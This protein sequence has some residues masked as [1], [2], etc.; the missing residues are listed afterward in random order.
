MADEGYYTQLG[1]EHQS[2]AAGD[3]DVV[4]FLEAVRD[5]GGAVLGTIKN[6]TAVNA[7]VSGGSINELP[8]SGLSETSYRSLLGYI[9]NI[10]GG[11]DSQ[12]FFRN[13][14]SSLVEPG[15]IAAL[16]SEPDGFLAQILFEIYRYNIDNAGS[17]D[18]SSRSVWAWQG[19]AGS[20]IL[21]NSLNAL[22]ALAE[23]TGVDHSRAEEP[24]NAED[25]EDAEELTG[26]AA[27]SF[28]LNRQQGVLATLNER[29]IQEKFGVQEICQKHI[30]P[31]NFKEEPYLINL[32]LKRPKLL[33]F[34]RIRTP[35]LSLLVPKIR[36]FKKV[37]IRQEDGTFEL[38]EQD[39]N[40]EFKFKSFTGNAEIQN[41]TD[42]NF[43]RA[44]GVGIKSANWSYEG[45]N[46][47][48][49]RSLLNFDLS[50]YFQSLS[51]LIGPDAGDAD[52]AL[53][54]T[55]NTDLINLIGAGVG[56]ADDFSGISRFK[57]E[58][59]AQLGWEID[60]SISHNLAAG[61]TIEEVQD[62]IKETNM[63]MRLALKEHNINFNE[64]GSLT[65]D[66]SYV[67]AID[68]VLASESL[69]IL[70]IGLPES[71]AIESILEAP[72]GNSSQG[73]SDE[74]PNL[75]LDPC[76]VS[77]AVTT[78]NQASNS[79]DENQ[80][81]S[82]R[83]LAVYEALTSSNED[84]IIQNYNSIFSRILEN[85]KIYRATVNV[86][87]AI[88]A[89]I[90]V[91]APGRIQGLANFVDRLANDQENTPTSRQ[92][93]LQQ[94]VER[95]T[96]VARVFT[97]EALRNINIGENGLTVENVPTNA[98][99]LLTDDERDAIITA[100]DQA[101]VG[102][103]PEL[104][105]DTNFNARVL[106]RLSAQ[107]GNKLEIDFIRLGDI[108]DSLIEGL[109]EVEGSPLK[110]R[111][112]DFLFL[113]GL[114]RYRDTTFS[115]RKAYNYA[116]MLISVDSFRSFFL[117][118]IVRPLKVNYGLINFI[119]DLAKTFSYANSI[120]LSTDERFIRA[121]GQP[122]LATFRAPNLG[123]RP[124][125]QSNTIEN[126]QDLS[127]IDVTEFTPAYYDGINA[128]FAGGYSPDPEHEASYFI[129][130]SSGGQLNFEGDEEEDNDRGIYHLRIGSDK[131]ILKSIKFRRDDIAGRRE[132]RIV[133]AGGANISAI[134]EKYD[135]TITLVGAPF[136]HPGTY[137]YVN[138]SSVGYGQS[139]SSASAARV[140]GLGGYYFV[141]KVQ[142]SISS[143]GNFETTIE[144]SWSAFADDGRGCQISELE[145]ISATPDSDLDARSILGL[146]DDTLMPG[147]VVGVASSTP[148]STAIVAAGAL[149][150]AV[151]IVEFVGGLADQA[152]QIVNF[153]TDE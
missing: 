32:L 16:E 107:N 76:A 85:N 111:P 83:D 78:G 115:Q 148:T 33:Q 11:A 86:D 91:R 79:D 44:G 4:G 153:L 95:T 25:A 94:R 118:K 45:T 141:N 52:E 5:E 38:L 97:E 55:G 53:R 109:T 41:I 58:I 131:G 98:E 20:R 40:L 112:E 135:A 19:A 99:E 27:V 67:S 54:A 138:P 8:G 122:M 2:N 89:V 114:Y 82:A 60:Q 6:L 22:R 88:Q 149:G 92:Q 104:E 31:I 24:M 134:R 36:L 137:L 127:Q 14:H 133:R 28:L 119:R 21:P 105:V 125:L 74:D 102:S 140:L 100:A 26:A 18:P 129:L 70:K 12:Q 68:D 84:N 120:K 75:E 121:E 147:G 15:A 63:N 77:R 66:I 93:A 50:L 145:I 72:A 87:E 143:D 39:G 142:N 117:E 29:I 7:T 51:D 35:Y 90:T 13:S 81:P 10:I 48:T 73:G 47:E 62:A 43:G 116:D 23:I 136:I 34:F 46:P 126:F 64:D 69:N 106:D 59:I 128:I 30:I 110:E 151:P 3:V 108:I 113:T 101:G 139:T 9:T 124:C 61:Q 17:G 146:G 56:V 132:G 123:L 65:L 144:A 152:G 96:V 57:F 80:E 71:S 1:Q 42:N 150:P 37:Y 130:R 103:I 49:V